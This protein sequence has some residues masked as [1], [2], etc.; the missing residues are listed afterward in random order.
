MAGSKFELLA[1]A[2]VVDRLQL[3][4]HFSFHDYDG[5]DRRVRH[6]AGDAKIDGDIDLDALFWDGVAG[7]WAESDLMVDGAI[8]NWEIDTSACFLAV[9]RDLECKNLI[10]SSADIRIGRDAKIDGVLS[11]TYNHGFLEVGGDAYARHIIIDD[12]ATI[13]RGKIEA[14]G[15]KEASNAEIALPDSRW[16]DEVSPEFRAEFFDA[17]GDMLCGNGNVALVQALLAGRE[18][19]RK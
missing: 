14:R 19:L 18:I 4:R 8:L 9:G 13:V 12:H 3:E 11:A 16:I 5:D 15:W 2:D 10:A 7:I 1:V 6:Y 17:D